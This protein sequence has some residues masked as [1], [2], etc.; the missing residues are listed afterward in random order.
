MKR[1]LDAIDKY[2]RPIT[3]EARNW[4]LLF[5]GGKLIS[6]QRC[7]DKS[8]T[9]D[10]CTRKANTYRL[11]LTVH[12]EINVLLSLSPD[13]LNNPRKLNKFTIVNV[14]INSKKEIC[15]SCCCTVCIQTLQKLGIR[16]II[17]SKADG[18]FV[19][20]SLEKMKLISKP[21]KGYKY[22]TN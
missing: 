10:I 17:Y 1:V 7:C 16:R 15:N 2:I 6:F 8:N 18:T 12:S 9:K 14:R 19:R 3:R 20:C 11:Y 5:K 22:I 13:V 4:T 21:S